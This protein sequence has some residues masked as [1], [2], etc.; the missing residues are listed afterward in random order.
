MLGEPGQWSRGASQSRGALLF[1]TALRSPRHASR[2]SAAFSRHR[3][4]QRVRRV[5]PSTPR[6]QPRRIADRARRRAEPDARHQWR[7]P[8][9][10]SSG[11]RPRSCG[12]PRHGL[13]D[14]RLPAGHLLQRRHGGAR[15]DVEGDWLILVQGGLL[16]SHGEREKSERRSL[17]GAPHRRR[18]DATQ[19]RAQ[20]LEFVRSGRAQRRRGCSTR[21]QA[22]HERR[23]PVRRT[24]GGFQCARAW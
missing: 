16:V 7:W 14:E 24:G 19:S 10:P 20:R 2:T 23:T 15:R 22:A 5:T 9:G 6:R 8:R 17:H 1:C 12:A 13:V 3:A 4:W 18:G 21:P 11:P